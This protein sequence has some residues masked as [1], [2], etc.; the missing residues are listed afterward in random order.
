[1][2][3]IICVSAIML[4][5]FN[6]K[7]QW[8]VEDVSVAA[9]LGQLNAEQSASNSKTIAEAT[10]TV[11]TLQSQSKWIKNTVEKVDDAVK[12]LAIIDEIQKNAVG[13]IKDYKTAVNALKGYKN[14]DKNYVQYSLKSL[15]SIISKNKKT[16]NF[17]SDIMK[18]DFLKLS[19]YERIK[20]LEDINGKII[21]L[22]QSIYNSSSD[23]YRKNQ[24]VSTR[25]SIYGTPVLK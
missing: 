8:I 14:L 6:A 10:T 12:S 5:A 17:Y 7:A 9:L 2:R 11:K 1:M 3:K 16:T 21:S 24:A 15:S 4:C 18:D 23:A 13:V 20:L 19:T 22:R 25:Q